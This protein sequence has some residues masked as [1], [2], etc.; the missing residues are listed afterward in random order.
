MTNTFRGGQSSELNAGALKVFQFR[1]QRGQR[2]FKTVEH[3]MQLGEFARAPHIFKRSRGFHGGS[4]AEGGNRT[5]ETVRRAF[6]RLGVAAC[7]RLMQLQKNS[8]II[9]HEQGG[10]FLQQI[11]IAADPRQGEVPIQA[12]TD[13]RT[14]FACHFFTLVYLSAGCGGL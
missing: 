9:L 11:Q 4:R 7:N 2:Q 5:F 1:T 13:G 3:R 12:L 14:G 8:W 6:H 10:D